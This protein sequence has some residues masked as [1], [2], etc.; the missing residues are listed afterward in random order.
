MSSGAFLGHQVPL[1]L[2][3]LYLKSQRV[4]GVRTGNPASV[5]RFWAAAGNTFRTEIDQVFPLAEAA[6]AHRYV[7]DSATVGRFVLAP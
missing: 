6:D 3:T 7:E 4:I 1:D 5:A 2:P